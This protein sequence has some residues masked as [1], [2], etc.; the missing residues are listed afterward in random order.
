MG[1]KA[2]NDPRAQR[3]ELTTPDA[4]WIKANERV[5]VTSSN[6]APHSHKH[7]M[8]IHLHHKHKNVPE[9]HAV[10]MVDREVKPPPAVQEEKTS[11]SFKDKLKGIACIGKKHSDE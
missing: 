5:D 8:P 2:V 7:H 11:T 3:M 6:E 4:D 9:V 1:I 10:D